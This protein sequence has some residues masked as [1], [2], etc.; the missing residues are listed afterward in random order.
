MRFWG[1]LPHLYP[2]FGLK[3][4]P[5]LF[6]RTISGLNGVQIRANDDDPE[7]V[8][9]IKV[10]PFEEF[11]YDRT[12][13]RMSITIGDNHICPCVTVY[14]SGMACFDLDSEWDGL[15]V[16]I[17]EDKIRYAVRE[18][19]FSMKKLFHDDIHH[20]TDPLGS[21]HMKY[22]DDNFAIVKASNLKEAVMDIFGMIVRKCE[23]T[24]SMYPNKRDPIDEFDSTVYSLISGS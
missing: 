3:Y 7:E 23:N 4:E 19:Y 11:T 21:S 1:W 6:A 16:R 14:N 24:L 12:A 13:F 20:K 5:Q 8:C 9:E 17:S 15:T 18:V 10:N 2:S 22:A